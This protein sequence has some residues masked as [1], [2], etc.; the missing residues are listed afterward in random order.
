MMKKNIVYS[1][2]FKVILI[3]LEF[4]PIITQNPYNPQNTTILIG[5]VLK[6]PF[7]NDVGF[8]LVIAKIVLLLILIIPFTKNKYSHKFILGYYTIILLISGLFQNMSNTEYGFTF[9]V[10]NMIL[11]FSVAGFCLYDFIKNKSVIA[12]EDIN[13]KS[14]W[15]IPLMFLALLMPYTINNN[16]VIPSVNSIFTN[17]AG[18]TY[19][20]ITPVIIGILILFNKEINK[21]TLHIISFVGAIF[22]VLNAMTWFGVDIQNWWMGIL[23]LP[24]LILSIYGLIVSKN[25]QSD[26]KKVNICD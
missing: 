1:W 25:K 2:W 3:L 24:L 5:D 18:V 8:A 10:G 7:I 13:K 20:M 14:L 21:P 12:K 22:G 4:C 23:H 19:C 15:I 11:E 6:H 16:T 17:E 9:I 26:N